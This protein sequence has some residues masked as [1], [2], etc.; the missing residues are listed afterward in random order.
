MVIFNLDS[1]FLLLFY[2]DSQL[3]FFSH[4][5]TL[6]ENSSLNLVIE[7]NYVAK[8]KMHKNKHGRSLFGR[9]LGFELKASHL[10]SRCSSA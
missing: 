9:V 5:A 3:L 10:L 6:N 8:L 2:V 4:C 7:I 1:M